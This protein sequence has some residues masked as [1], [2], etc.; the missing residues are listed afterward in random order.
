M[1]VFDGQ[2]VSHMFGFA[3]GNPAVDP[4]G[5]PRHQGA[6]T[7][8]SVTCPLCRVVTRRRDMCTFLHQSQRAEAPHGRG[9][10]QS[11]RPEVLGEAGAGEA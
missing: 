3:A 2:C 1:H 7:R 8:S 6:L 11:Q 10:S 5:E 4:A 9:D